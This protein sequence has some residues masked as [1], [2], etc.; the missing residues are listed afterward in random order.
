MITAYRS[1][2]GPSLLAMALCCL[3][4][5]LQLAFAQNVT[6][7][8]KDGVRYQVTR[9]VTQRQVPT[10]VMQ[11]RQQTTYTQQLITDTYNHQQLYSVPVTQYQWVSRLR[12]R[13]NP[14]IT[15][16][17]THQLNPVTHWQQQVANVQV[18]VSRVA[19]SPQ[20][21]TV[22]VPV[23][24]F[25]T[26]EEETVTRVAVN[27]PRTLASAQP[28]QTRTATL[29]ARPSMVASGGVALD[30]DPPRQATGWRTPGNSHYR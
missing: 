24:Q 18:P 27:P 2:A 26:A 1:I 19:W 9:R 25:R 5:S 21:Q 13:W 17:W 14:F 11:D 10:T 12:G 29:A 3:A 7:E 8:E 16:Y 4:P 30:N 20:T 22:Q 15:P 28:I 6:Y 23:T